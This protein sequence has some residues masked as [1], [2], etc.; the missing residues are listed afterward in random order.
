MWPVATE[1]NRAALED[2]QGKGNALFT[3]WNLGLCDYV[4]DDTFKPPTMN[5]LGSYGLT[6][7]KGSKNLVFLDHLK[8]KAGYEVS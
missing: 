4:A 6:L 2:F 5:R 7:P 8:I 3:L 1:L